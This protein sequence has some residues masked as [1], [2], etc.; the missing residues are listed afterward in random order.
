MPPVRLWPPFRRGDLLAILILALLLRLTLLAASNDQVGTAK[1]LE[2]CWDCRA[3]I[4]AALY[5]EGQAAGAGHYLFYYGPGYPYFLALINI[6]FNSHPVPLLV[7]N[8]ALSALS[9]LLIY[10]LAIRL[11]ESY[12]LAVIAALLSAISYTSIMLSCVIMSDTFYFFIFLSGLIIY[13]K[14]LS[15][16]RWRWF[17]LSGFLVG[18]AILTRSIGQFWPLVMIIIAAVY[19]RGHRKSGPTPPRAI[20]NMLVKVSVA[21][22]IP[23]IILSAWMVRNYQVH[24][25][26]ALAI[27]SA[28]G[29]A[30]LAA[31]TIERLEGT[32]ANQTMTGWVEEYKGATGRS[33]LALGEVFRVYSTRGW[34][35]LDT[36]KWEAA[37]TY[38]M[39]LWENLNSINFLHRLLVPRCGYFMFPVE[40]FI[41]D[42]YLN[43]L[44]F[45]LSMLGFLILLLRRKF[46]TAL[47]LACVYG[48]Y[49]SMLGFYRWQYSRHFL[50]GQIAWAIL[51]AIVIVSAGQFFRHIFRWLIK[52]DTAAK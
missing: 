22:M 24:G 23:I 26:F 21:V 52:I 50:P 49:A 9:C 10:S 37:K 15:D 3:Y 29:P 18:A 35:T 11:T 4:N 19:I 34:E 6:F 43:C 27:T 41:G 14:G 32:P 20:S 51:I 38:F 1:V 25:V 42:H 12:P 28:N 44:C 39:I 8:I 48:Y 40:I 17:I 33:S 30:S 31:Q 7:F 36:L 5:L 46:Q 16:W 45:V 2:D 13:L 47:V